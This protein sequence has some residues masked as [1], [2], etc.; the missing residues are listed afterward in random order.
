MKIAIY[1]MDVIAGNPRANERKVQK[2]VEETMEA[3]KPDILVLPEMWTTA[4]TLKELQELAED[5]RRETERFLQGLAKQ[6]R[7]NL[8]AGSYATKVKNKIFNRAFVFNR[9]G[10]L[11]YH[12]D[13]IHLVPMLDEPR[14]LEAGEKHAEVFELDGYK[15]GLVICYD[16]RFPELIRGLAL[17]GANVLF[18]VAEWPEARASHW[19]ILQQARAIEN[20]CYVV[21]SNRVGTYDNVEFAGRSFVI[22]P[23][24]DVEAKGSQDQEETITATIDV[25]KVQEMRELV[26]VFASRVPTKY[27]KLHEEATQINGK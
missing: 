3:E 26:P 4:Y 25:G 24:G 13:K 9:S 16:L 8:V 17:A 19:Q 22:N 20:Q 23:W 10:E 5:D 2:W 6:H 18:V 27:K 7:V 14:Y 12:Y 21:S 11:V 15:M 1:Q